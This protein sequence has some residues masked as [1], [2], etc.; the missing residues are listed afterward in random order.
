VSCIS[1]PFSPS[2]ITFAWRSSPLVSVVYLCLY[3]VKHYCDC[4]LLLDSTSDERLSGFRIR[5][6]GDLVLGGAMIS[7]TDGILELKCSDLQLLCTCLILCSRSTV[8]TRP[9]TYKDMPTHPKCNVCLGDISVPGIQSFL[10]WFAA[11]IALC[12]VGSTGDSVASGQMIIYAP[13]LSLSPPP[14][15]SLAHIYTHIHTRAHT[16]TYTYTHTL[17]MLFFMVYYC[18]CG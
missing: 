3:E 10:G 17:Y 2:L 15:L 8:Q 7:A 13:F 4:R 18:R 12:P 9:I 11:S 6:P 14:C 5:A 16:Y 1:V